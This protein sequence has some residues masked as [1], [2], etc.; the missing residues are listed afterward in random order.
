MRLAEVCT[1]LS[2]EAICGAFSGEEHEVAAG[3]AADL[4]SD[5]LANAAKDS[6]LITGLTSA[7]VIHT[8]DVAEMRAVVFVNGKKP[9]P[10]VIVMA[11]ELGLPL[12]TTHHTMFST[13]GLLWAAGLRVV[14]EMTTP[15]SSYPRMGHS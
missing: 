8:A 11:K 1:L 14:V 12:L 13:C 3:F 5:V 2:C 4:M 6:L 7:Q 10:P 15:Q 9:A